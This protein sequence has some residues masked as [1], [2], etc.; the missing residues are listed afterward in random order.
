MSGNG[1]SV[2]I[3]P[4]RPGDRDGFAR[5]VASVLGEYGFVVDPVLEADLDDPARAYGAVWVA[6]DPDGGGGDLVGSVAIRVLDGGDMAELKR[7]YLDPAYR[8]Q[9][10][11]RAL[12]NRAIDWARD[13]GCRVIVLDTSGAMVAAKG[14]YESAGFVRTG[15]R[16]EVGEHDS[17]CEVLYRLE[18]GDRS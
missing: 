8:G 3:E 15:T 11:G 5:L 1:P 14:L 16:T 9:G 7:M 2:D 13:R 12:L 18:L 4:Y 17:R 10:I 6:R